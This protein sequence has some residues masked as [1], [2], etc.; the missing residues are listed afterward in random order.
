L[1]TGDIVQTSDAASFQ[2]LL[3]V[4]NDSNHFTTRLLP[5]SG[6][7]D[8][9]SDGEHL[10]APV[11]EEGRKVPPESVPRTPTIPTVSDL[12]ALHGGPEV[13]LT[14]TEVA[15]RLRVC[16]QTVYKLCARGALVHVR[17]IASIR[18][19]LADLDAYIAAQ[20]RAARRWRR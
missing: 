4:T 14:V 9:G 19:R 15:Q 18:V 13:L 12:H 3:T 16:T 11:G 10:P 5:T 6:A 1:Q 2:L 8:V 20:D 17:I 7:D